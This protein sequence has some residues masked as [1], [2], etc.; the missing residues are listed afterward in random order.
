[1]KKVKTEAVSREFFLVKS[2][3]ELKLTH[4]YESICSVYDQ[5][6]KPHCTPIGIQV[7]AI[8]ENTTYELEARIFATAKMYAELSSQKACTIHFPGYHQLQY[9][10]L[11]FQDELKEKMNDI[12]KMTGMKKAKTVN[13]PLIPGIKN[14]I[15]AKVISIREE[16]VKDEISAESDESSRLGIF[17]LESTLIVMDDPMSMPVSRHGGILLELMIEASRLKYLN[18]SG[19][20]FENKSKELKKMLEKLEHIAPGDE[21][22]A[23]AA[24]ILGKIDHEQ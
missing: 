10:F 6:G 9:F 22:N 3:V 19:E 16:I 21:K 20:K 1:M 12:V 18:S 7:L 11:A 14:Y 15:E 8:H 2:E 13:A 5:E 4:I 23:I 24:I 17:S